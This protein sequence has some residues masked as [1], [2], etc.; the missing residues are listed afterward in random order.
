MAD[1]IELNVNGKTYPVTADP[2]TPL[3]YVLRNE[4]GFKGVKS[5][6]G[7]EQC[8]ACNVLID[9]EAVP[10]CKLQVGTLNGAKIITI[11]GLGTPENL[12]PLQEAFIDQQAIQCGYC[13]T[14][15]IISAQGLLNKI[16]YPTEE[17][18]NQALD[19]NLCRCGTH[20]RVRR[21]IK[22]RI[23]RPDQTPL[24]QTL[25]LDPA[26]GTST[27]IGTAGNPQFRQLG[28]DRSR[29]HDHHFQR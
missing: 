13:T 20:E 3:L 9:G 4:L 18:I 11:E 10:S 12:H 1:A 23:A 14:G 24:T 28:Q 15:L 16:R 2:Q 8:G 7:L 5:A 26:A 25:S 19:G 29:R 6:C 21:A 27:P 22:L 17:Q